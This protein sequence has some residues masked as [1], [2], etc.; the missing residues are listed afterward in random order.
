MRFGRDEF[1]DDAGVL[2]A[3]RGGKEI[4]ARS[5][6]ANLTLNLSYF[7]QRVKIIIRHNPIITLELLI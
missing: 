3:H 1:F 6:V 2:S 7:F 4:Q 5:K